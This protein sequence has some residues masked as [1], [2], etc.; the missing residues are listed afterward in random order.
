V[1]AA[2]RRADGFDDDYLATRLR[3]EL[4]LFTDSDAAKAPDGA[5]QLIRYYC[6]EAFWEPI[7]ELRS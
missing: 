1:P 4:L 7:D 6:T 2:D 3:H 5:F